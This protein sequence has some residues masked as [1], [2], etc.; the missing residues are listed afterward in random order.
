MFSKIA[1]QYRTQAVGGSD[2]CLELK[3]GGDPSEFVNTDQC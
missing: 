2:L 3:Q 1:V